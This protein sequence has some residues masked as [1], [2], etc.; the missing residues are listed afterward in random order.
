MPGAYFAARTIAL[1]LALLPWLRV[2][3]EVGADQRTLAAAP[4]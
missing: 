1:S 4:R 2:V 3:R